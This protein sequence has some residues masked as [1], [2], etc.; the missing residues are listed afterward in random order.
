MQ[1]AVTQP[2]TASTMPIASRLDVREALVEAMSDLRTA[3]S[4]GDF[5]EISR[6]ASRARVCGR[7]VLEE[8]IA[9]I[10]GG[11]MNVLVGGLAEA[12]IPPSTFPTL[13]ST[14]DRTEHALRILVADQVED[15]STDGEV[16]VSI[17]STVPARWKVDCD[18]IRATGQCPQCSSSTIGRDTGRAGSV[19]SVDIYACFECNYEVPYAE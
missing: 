8:D 9:L 18:K 17:D 11:R 2:Q 1:T 6:A 5:A 12:G 4:G 19:G 15:L 3:A 16:A 7:A 13:R 14:A 10:C